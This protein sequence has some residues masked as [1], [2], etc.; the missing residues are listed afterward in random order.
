[1]NQDMAQQVDPFL[2]NRPAP[3]VE[4]EVVVASA[5][6]KGIVMRRSTDDPPPKTHRTKGEPA[7]QK[8]MAT[9]ATVY[10]VDRY[11]RTPEQVVAAL[12][13]DAPQSAADRPRPQH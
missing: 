8:R 6:Q 3:E 12:F 4:G 9:V 5:D 10:S 1:M 7:S 2:T 13:R 11:R